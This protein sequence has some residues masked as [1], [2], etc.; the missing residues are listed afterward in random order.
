MEE[1][2]GSGASPSPGSSAAGTTGASGADSSGTALTGGGNAPRPP[3]HLAHIKGWGADLDHRNRPAYP[4]ERTPPR[5][6]DVQLWSNPAQQQSHIEV[7]HSTERPGVTPVFGTSSPPWG[8]SGWIRRLAYRLSENDIRHWL[9]LL[10]A[11]RVNVV[12]GIGDDL[13]RGHVPNI[14]AEMGIKAELQHNRTGFVTKVAVATAVV[15]VAWWLMRRREPEPLL[16]DW[17][18]D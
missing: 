15:G 7:F 18:E 13:V 10:F 16:E 14:P 12:E 4:M 9:L 2:Q 3:A 11:D 1:Q 6:G 8:V 17:E 5:L